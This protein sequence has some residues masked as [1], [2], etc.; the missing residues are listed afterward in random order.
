L[1]DALR[2]HENEGKQQSPAIE[3][4]FTPPSIFPEQGT[5]VVHILVASAEARRI[6]RR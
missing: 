6:L 5:F 1:F 3:D 2:R 4:G